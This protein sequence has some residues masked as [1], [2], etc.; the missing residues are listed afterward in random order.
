MVSADTYVGMRRVPCFEGRWR[1]GCHAD[2]GSF[3]SY[4][5]VLMLGM[6]KIE[7]SYIKNEKRKYPGTKPPPGDARWL[8]DAWSDDGIVLLHC[9]ILVSFINVS[10]LCRRSNLMKDRARTDVRCDQTHLTRVL[11]S[12]RGGPSTNGRWRKTGTLC[13]TGDFTICM[14]YFVPS[15]CRLSSAA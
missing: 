5:G 13:A 1:Q 3:P 11:F 7:T 14:H 8:C 6:C 12:C 4:V 9:D 15:F 10:E 2:T